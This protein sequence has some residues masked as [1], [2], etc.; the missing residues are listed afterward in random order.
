M[1][2]HTISLPLIGVTLISPPPSLWLV[3]EDLQC[4]N[5]SVKYPKSD[6]SSEGITTSSLTTQKISPRPLQRLYRKCSN[7]LLRLRPAYFLFYLDLPGRQKHC[8]WI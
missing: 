8:F 6:F 3:L 4:G 2:K 5:S 7:G 1:K